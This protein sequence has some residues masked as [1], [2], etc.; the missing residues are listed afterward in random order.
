MIGFLSPA[1]A[2]YKCEYWEHKSKAEQICKEVY[3]KPF[4]RPFDAIGFL[5]EHNWLI[6]YS[7]ELGHQQI[8]YNKPIK[9]RPYS[10]NY[11][12][13]EQKSWM[14]SHAEQLNTSQLEDYQRILDED[15]TLFNSI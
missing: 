11:I 1:G 10:I 14:D 4:S 15:T 12:T 5:L 7:R 8:N 3:N 2:F 9:T 13:S 6:L